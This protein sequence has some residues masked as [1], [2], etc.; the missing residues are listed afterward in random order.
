MTPGTTRQQSLKSSIPNAKSCTHGFDRFASGMCLAYFA[1]LV[2]I[3]FC[4]V[5]LCSTARSDTEWFK[6]K[7]LPG[8][9]IDGVVEGGR[10]NAEFI[11]DREKSLSRSDASMS[12][13]HKKFGQFCMSMPLSISLKTKYGKIKFSPILS[14]E[15]KVNGCS[16]DTEFSGQTRDV[17]T[18]RSASM[19]LTCLFIV[20][21]RSGIANSTRWIR[22]SLG[23]HVAHVVACRS[24]EEMIWIAAPSVVATMENEEPIYNRSICQKPGKSMSKPLNFSSDISISVIGQ[25]AS[26]FPATRFKFIESGPKSVIG[27]SMMLRVATPRSTAGVHDQ[28]RKFSMLPFI[29]PAS[30][31]NDMAGVV[32]QK[33]SPGPDPAI[34]LVDDGMFK[35]F[36]CVHAEEHSTVS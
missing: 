9:T 3:Q 10:A 17:L 23:V 14:T 21:L 30:R 16:T 29:G 11:S 28:R 26:P 15:N 5:C 13:A 6:P 12:L 33:T 4:C 7:M 22:S 18:G 27:R 36:V 32:K 31:R 24:E 35:T 2:V 1:Y 34:N 8:F 19:D 25:S 20:H